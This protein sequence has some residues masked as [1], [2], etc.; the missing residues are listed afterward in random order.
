MGASSIRGTAEAGGAQVAPASAR[1]FKSSL[2][3]R[4]LKSSLRE[5]DVAA[6]RAGSVWLVRIMESGQ[7]LN[8]PVYTPELLRASPSIFEGAPVYSFQFGDK[9]RLKRG[10]SKDQKAAQGLNHLPEQVKEADSRGLVGNMVGALEGVHF[11]EADQAL[12]AYLVVY[13]AD[14]RTLLREAHD[15]GHIGDGAQKNVLGLSIDAQGEKAEDGRTVQRFT[16]ATSV[17]LVTTPAAG[18]RIRR[19]IEAALNPDEPPVA[20]ETNMAATPTTTT[21]MPQALAA[22][23]PTGAPAAPAPTPA[24][25]TLQ[26]SAIPAPAP[27]AAP[28]PAVTVK[29]G[30]GAATA[31]KVKELADRLAGATDQEMPAIMAAIGDLVAGG[32]APAAPMAEGDKFAQLTAGV[33]G[34]HEAV[35]GDAKL[36]ESVEGFAKLA[37]VELA[38]PAGDPKDRLIES[39]QATIR[40]NAIQREMATLAGTLGLRE[41]V[42]P[43]VVRLA[44]MGAVQVSPDGKTVSGLSEALKEAVSTRP[45]FLR[46]SAT[47]AAPAQAPTTP[48]P[49]AAPAAPAAAP[50]IAGMQVTKLA[51]SAGAPRPRGQAVPLRE[52]V[53]DAPAMTDAQA[54]SRYKSLI[55]AMRS[56]NV[57]ALAEGTCLR[58][59]HNIAV[60]AE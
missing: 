4:V 11:N 29:E 26:A 16:A 23:A 22:A 39:L 41:G 3:A 19:L 6:E 27:A 46:E 32:K 10:A 34:L 51:E 1:A 9:A 53:Q 58:K 47:A 49:A 17:D 42:L 55:P 31:A 36:R 48:A 5:A 33:K 38:A 18:G 37:G 30:A 21:L 40:E 44:N 24:P 20:E 59:R 25:A 14:T 35:K 52:S 54:L 50:T 56:G 60:Q 13:D 7:S 2:R 45:Y 28:A 43:D 8:G 12:D 15:A 57:S